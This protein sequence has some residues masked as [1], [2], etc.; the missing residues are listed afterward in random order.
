MIVETGF[1]SERSGSEEKYM[2]YCRHVGRKSKFLNRNLPFVISI[3]DPK[4]KI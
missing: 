3:L 1:A 4:M 2:E